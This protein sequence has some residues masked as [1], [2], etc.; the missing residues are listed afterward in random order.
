MQST[1]LFAAEG[2]EEF[3]KQLTE[4]MERIEAIASHR[5]CFDSNQCASLAVGRRA[6]GGSAGFVTYSIQLGH[7]AT[8]EL[9]TLAERSRILEEKINE[10]EFL[11][12]ICTMAQPP[13]LMC[14]DHRCVEQSRWFSSENVELAGDS[15]AAIIFATGLTEISGHLSKRGI[16]DDVRGKVLF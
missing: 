2:T 13:A 7:D 16:P 9:L 14:F 3:H 15:L 5:T 4:T 10:A 1:F 6:C 11:I 8:I 12:S